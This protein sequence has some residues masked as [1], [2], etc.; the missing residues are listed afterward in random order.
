M[1]GGN[2]NGRSLSIL[3]GLAAAALGGVYTLAMLGIGGA[4]AGRQVKDAE[5]YIVAGRK[6]GFPLLFGTV[7]ATWICGGLFMGGM[8]E[9][10]KHGFQGG[11]SS[12]Q[13]ALGCGFWL[14][15][16]STAFSCA[17]PGT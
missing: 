12:I 8:A 7:L 16:S 14:P 11:L 3:G 13:W 1:T 6:L 9:S 15:P 17:G 10:Y 5:D 2:G 4:W